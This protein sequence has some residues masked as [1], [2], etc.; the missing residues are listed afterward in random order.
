MRIFY[1]TEDRK[2]TGSRTQ[3]NPHEWGKRNHAACCPLAFKTLP[4]QG[5]AASGNVPGP[6]PV[7]Q[8]W[9]ADVRPDSTRNFPGANQ[10]PNGHSP[11]FL[12]L[13]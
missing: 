13:A 1:R 10:I 2:K 6:E 7:P 8:K 12:H 5:I 4:K 3:R 9:G 11:G